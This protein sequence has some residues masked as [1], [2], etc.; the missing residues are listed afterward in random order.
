MQ[1]R[2]DLFAPDE[3]IVRAERPDPASP[4]L[5]GDFE[6]VAGLGVTWQT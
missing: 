3:L 5:W 1:P 6:A 2:P 4:R